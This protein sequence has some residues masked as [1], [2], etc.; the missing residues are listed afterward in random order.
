MPILRALL[1]PAQYLVWRSRTLRV[2]NLLRFAETEAD[3][4]RDIVRAA[5]IT[6]DPILRRLFIFHAK[7]EQR[8]ADL[9]RK[10]APACCWP[11]RAGRAVRC[12]AA[13]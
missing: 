13:G 11:C 3:G 2:R 12:A 8:H 10:R 9:F 7:D 4:G 1:W 5:D 6:Q